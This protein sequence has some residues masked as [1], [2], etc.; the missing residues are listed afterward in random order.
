MTAPTAVREAPAVARAGGLTTR[1]AVPL[2]VL[3]EAASLLTEAT[4]ITFPS[5]R[6]SSLRRALARL[7][8][9]SGAASA[10]HVLVAL[11]REPGLMTRLISLVR[12]GETY[13]FRHPE[14]LAVI[15]R[16]ILPTLA[17]STPAG[18]PPAID[19]WSAGCSTG[20]EAYSLAII[21][22][23]AF[24]AEH[25]PAVRI[26][27]T[28]I[29][30]HAV[31][32]AEAGT[33]GRWSFRSPLGDLERWFEGDGRNRRV[34]PAIRSR[35]TFSRDNLADSSAALPP[36]LGAAPGV[37]VCRN[38]LMY[39]SPD[40]RRRV[41][42]RFLRLLAPGGWLIVAPVELSGELYPGFEPVVLETSTVYRRPLTSARSR[43]VTHTAAKT[44]VGPSRSG[45]AGAENADAAALPPGDRSAAATSPAVVMRPARRDT[46]SGARDPHSLAVIR[47]LADRGNLD[48][49]WRLAAL[50]VRAQPSDGE[51][52]HLLATIAEARNDLADAAAALRRAIYLDR[53]DAAAHFRLGLIEWRQGHVRQATK[54]LARAVRL[55]EGLDDET[56]LD[57]SPD[58]TAARVRTTAAMMRHD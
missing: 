49:A 54:R 43:S 40:A 32:V 1:D 10:D 24:P 7:A 5:G 14:Q 51:A 58:L 27:A 8:A 53:A 20:E 48:D 55:V 44:V 2:P 25:G 46:A 17:A 13:F 36:G 39:L 23:E 42:A 45:P 3:D 6:R 33:Y 29:D 56:L 28:D 41:A 57:G 50:A 26:A 15:A 18:R 4:G 52:Q 30:P 19:I 11:G 34:L 12:V 21:A 37:I 16:H 9:E 47:A 22:A 31:R 38:V 35:V